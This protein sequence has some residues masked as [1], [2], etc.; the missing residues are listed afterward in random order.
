[1]FKN[2][3]Y[4]II[5]AVLAEATKRYEVKIEHFKMMDNHYHM[6]LMTPS[7]NI[8]IIMWFINNQIA[9]RINKR[10]GVTGHLWGNRYHATIVQTDEH[11]ERCVWYIYN[12]GVKAG[13]CNK[14][15][16]DERFSTFDFYARGKKID[17]SVNEDSVYLMLGSS[18]IERQEAFLLMVDGLQNDEE[19]KAI[20]NGLRKL[21]YGS[22]DFVESM[23]TKYLKH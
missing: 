9:K 14:A 10:N 3:T 20:R 8:D 13:L 19:I 21:F 18:S 5:I 15:S 12:N 22:A 23:K 2:W 6:K 1:M 11:A 4:K 17:F 7:S 16:E